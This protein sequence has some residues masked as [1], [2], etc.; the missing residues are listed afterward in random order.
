MGANVFANGMEISGKA[1]GNQS[2]AAMP[3]VC[4]SPPS[5]PA[6][7]VPIPYPNT[8]MASDT[9]DGTK[10]V[11]I[12]GKEVGMKNSSSY[13]KSTG[14]EP[15]TQSFGGNTVSHKIQG[16]TKFSAW[17]SDVKL[18]GANA[19]RFGD[20]TTHNHSNPQG[21]S[22]ITLNKG[23]ASAKKPDSC[24]EMAK[25]NDTDRA[26]MAKAS[27]QKVS[28]LPKGSPRNAIARASVGRRRGSMF[29]ASRFKVLDPLCPKK[30]LKQG[31][32]GTENPSTSQT[33]CPGKPYK[34]P[35]A[36][37]PAHLHAEARLLESVVLKGLTTKPTVTLAIDWRQA[38]KPT[39]RKPC[40]LCKRLIEHACNCMKI[41]ICDENNEPQPQCP[42]GK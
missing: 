17:S 15:A 19:V 25:K 12:G 29:S 3:D 28:G 32:G 33:V 39:K 35:K 26:A 23:G 16:P 9:T 11:K 8:A 42:S 10:T 13:S 4:M 14:D 37:P 30:T 24:K 7:P 22:G 20:M 41:Q 40:G 21:A 38:G 5:P 36:I 27:E 34:F 1:S 6:G 18:E 31:L 2:L